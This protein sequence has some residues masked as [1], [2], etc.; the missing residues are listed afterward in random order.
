MEADAEKREDITAK[1]RHVEEDAAERKQVTP[2]TAANI[3][4]EVPQRRG[5]WPRRR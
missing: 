2:E 4:E 1:K 3:R 5:G